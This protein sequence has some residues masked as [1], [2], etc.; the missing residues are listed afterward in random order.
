MPVGVVLLVQGL[1]E[2]VRGV[3][4]VG[5]YLLGGYSMGALIAFEMTRQL[6]ATGET[7][8]FL[9]IL[10]TPAL[11][12]RL[13]LDLDAL[14]YEAA[15][16]QELRIP[17]TDEEIRSLPPDRRLPLIIE[18][19]L[20]LGVLPKGFRIADAAHYLRRFQ[21][22]F[23]A[24]RT[25]ELT[26]CEARITFFPSEVLTSHEAYGKDSTL[27]W[28]VLSRSGVDVHP[29]AG[30]HVT[31]LR[32]PHVESLARQLAESMERSAAAVAERVGA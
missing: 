14:L 3:Q 15:L 29:M 27:G 26:D 16:A 25:Y 18:R 30:N 11:E 12:F 19:G 17:V 9:G 5:P 13:D 32:P 21:A 1:L 22:T 7:V 10:D 24:Y 23:Q 2:E 20:E 6:E 4:S 8:A 28:G 31:M